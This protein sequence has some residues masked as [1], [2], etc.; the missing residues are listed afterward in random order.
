MSVPSPP[1]PGNEGHLPWQYSTEYAVEVGSHNK[2]SIRLNPRCHFNDVTTFPS[3]GHVAHL[4]FVA[5]LNFSQV[6]IE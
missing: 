2:L 6:L 4:S 1:I 5:W 3:L